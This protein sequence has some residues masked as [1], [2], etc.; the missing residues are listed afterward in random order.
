MRSRTASTGAKF[1]SLGADLDPIVYYTGRRHKGLGNGPKSD[2][3]K[4]ALAQIKGQYLNDHFFIVFIVQQ[5][6]AV[7]RSNV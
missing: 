7:L 3:A 2:V 5:G 1:D 4:L 6:L